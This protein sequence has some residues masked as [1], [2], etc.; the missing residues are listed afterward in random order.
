MRKLEKEQIAD[1]LRQYC[2]LKGSQNKAASSLR[3]VSAATLS[4]MLNENWELITEEMW[5]NVAVQIGH[6]DRQW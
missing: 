5:R 6:D 1:Q 3:G 4:Q 2:E